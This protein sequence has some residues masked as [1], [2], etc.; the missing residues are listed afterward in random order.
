MGRTLVDHVFPLVR[1]FR[2]QNVSMVGRTTGLSV[3]IV[4][5]VANVMVHVVQHDDTRG[6]IEQ[7]VVEG[8]GSH[9]SLSFGKDGDSGAWIFD[10]NGVLIG[11]VWGGC[12]SGMRVEMCK[13]LVFALV[14]LIDACRV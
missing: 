11:I 1:F 9:P 7:T 6:I 3:G 10:E 8:Q 4:R 13:E 2:S 12:S 5:P 14:L